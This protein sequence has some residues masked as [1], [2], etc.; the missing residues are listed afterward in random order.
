M[1]REEAINELIDA[2]DG[3]K[4]YLSNEALSMA[5]EALEQESILDKMKVE[6]EKAIWEESIFGFYDKTVIKIP[7]LDP[8][9]VFEIIDKYKAE[10]EV[11]NRN[12]D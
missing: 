5:I 8:K 6:I 12:D 7:R 4:E 11:K 1:T 10:S 9:V 3:Y 2:K